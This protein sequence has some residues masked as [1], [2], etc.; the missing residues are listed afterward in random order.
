M[1]SVV[2]VPASCRTMRSSRMHP[3][4]RFRWFF[5]RHTLDNANQRIAFNTLTSE[6][7]TTNVFNDGWSGET[8]ILRN[9]KIYRLDMA[10]LTFTRDT[11]LWRSKIF[12]RRTRRTLLLYRVYFEVP[13]WAPFQSKPRNTDPKVRY[14]TEPVNTDWCGCTPM[15]GLS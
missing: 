4:G 6:D 12:K 11:A 10:D 1:H 5:Q 14:S 3:A 9:D 13:T 2:S 8:L 7:I 15:I